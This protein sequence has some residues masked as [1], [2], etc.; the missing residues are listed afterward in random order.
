MSPPL[1]TKRMQINDLVQRTDSINA[2]LYELKIF[3]ALS[4]ATS[5]SFKWLPS[6]FLPSLTDR[7]SAAGQ[8][9]DRQRCRS[10]R[11]APSLPS[12][13]AAGNV[14]LEGVCLVCF[15]VIIRLLT[16]VG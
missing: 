6:F 2:T 14:C 16:V 5:V 9:S 3:M 12:W 13:L 15:A 10:S 7:P 4:I 11:S 1:A 8:A